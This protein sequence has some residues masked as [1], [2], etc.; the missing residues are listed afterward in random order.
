MIDA[1]HHRQGPIVGGGQGF[2]YAPGPVFPVDEV[3][4]GAAG[5]DAQK[6]H[7]AVRPKKKG[8]GISPVPF[9]V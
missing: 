8:N 2:E 1:F 4:K 6:D 5:V 7:D 3:R 9:E